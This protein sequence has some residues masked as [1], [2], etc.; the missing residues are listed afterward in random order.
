MAIVGAGMVG[1]TLAALLGRVGVEV[2]LIDARGLPDQPAE[3][4]LEGRVVALGAAAAQILRGTGAAVLGR[5][6]CP[7]EVMRVWA[8]DPSSELR[9]DAAAIGVPS[10]GCIAANDLVVGALADELRSLPGV[11]LLAPARI[12][13]LRPAEKGIILRLADGA[14]VA[15]SL[16]VGADGAGSAVRR[17]AGL[18]ARRR[19]YGQRAIVAAIETERPNRGVAWQR[20]LPD[21]PLA[22]LPLS[23]GRSSIVWSAETARAEALLAMEEADFLAAL[24]AAFQ[25]RLGM[26]VSSG[27]RAAFPLIRQHAPR[28]VGERVALIGDAAHVI[29]P[30]AGQG[31]NLG[32]LDAAALAEL[33]AEEVAAGRDPGRHSMLRRYERWRK[34]E[35][36]L[37]MWAMD[38]LHR[39]FTSRASGVDW[40]R[41]RGLGLVDA[42]G[43]LKN[44]LVRRA[45][46]LQGDLPTLA[47]GP[48]L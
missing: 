3:R 33:V 40:L 27:P 48:L 6:G 13:A 17:L 35:N 46:G 31:A 26:P 30:L 36:L 11:R 42:A 44:H 1:A 21:G 37:M 15:A 12:T 20:F 10:L 39:L 45:M 2:V 4:P 14:E 25:W 8:S 23:D 29:H 47:R 9:F 43:P 32:L 19:D 16:V 34:G 28:Y 38:G 22:F 24:G 7:Y 5:H 41:S 18:E